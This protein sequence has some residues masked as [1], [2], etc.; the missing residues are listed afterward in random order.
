V[1]DDRRKYGV[2]AFTSN[3]E[4]R[5]TVLGI[6]KMSDKTYTFQFSIRVISF[7]LRRHIASSWFSL[8]V[9]FKLDQVMVLY[10]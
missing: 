8:G 7:N 6:F 5:R 9:I 1:K 2:S 3:S 10:G 4:Y